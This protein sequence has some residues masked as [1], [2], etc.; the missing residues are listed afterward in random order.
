MQE[1]MFHQEYQSSSE[2]KYRFAWLVATQ[3]PPVNA[4][5]VDPDLILLAR[6]ALDKDW[7]RRSQLTLDDFRIESRSLNTIALQLLGSNSSIHKT[8]ETPKS[9]LRSRLSTIVLD[10]EAQLASRLLGMEIQATHSIEDVG[11]LQKTV[12]LRWDRPLSDGLQAASFS[13]RVEVQLLH[14]PTTI[15]LRVLLQML[16]GND[17]LEKQAALADCPDSEGIESRLEQDVIQLFIDMANKLTR[18]RAG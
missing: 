15:G 14:P 11:E 10:L 8:R 1:Q 3:D 9:T 6:R 16:E 7:R 5:D 2:N 12:V 17:R 4:L 13:L 18:E